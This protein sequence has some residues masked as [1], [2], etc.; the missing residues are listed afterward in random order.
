M[1]S[2]RRKR[3]SQTKLSVWWGLLVLAVFAVGWAA[4][5]DFLKLNPEKPVPAVSKPS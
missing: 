5:D 1:G 4:V 2:K 3:G